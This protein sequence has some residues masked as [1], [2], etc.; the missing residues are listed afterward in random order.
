MIRV[1]CGNSVFKDILTAI[2]SYAA[3]Q[4]IIGVDP[5]ENPFVDDVDGIPIISL[6]DKKLIASSLHKV[7]IVDMITE[8]FNVLEHLR[9]Y[10]K[11]KTYILFANGSWHQSQ[12]D[13]EINH[14][15][16]NWNYFLYD[17]VNRSLNPRVVD[18]WQDKNY[19]FNKNKEFVFSALI[20]GKRSWRDFLV[21][22]IHKCLTADN[23]VLNY[24]GQEL[25]QSSRYD[26]IPYDRSQ[27]NSCK[28]IY[29]HYTLSSSIPI[30]LYNKSRLLLIVEATMYEHDEFHLTEKTIKALLT[31]IPFVVCGSYKFLEQLRAL[32][33]KTYS[34]VW[35][36]EYD[37]IQNNQDRMASIVGLL[38][39]ISTMDWDQSTVDKLQNIA[40]HNK[41]QLLNV[42]SIM[43]QQILTIVDQFKDFNI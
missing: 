10:P 4:K 38:N 11:D 1:N 32:G 42:N 20:G 43:K 33:F 14:I 5:I 37:L 9:E 36:E 12:T 15:V 6:T 19:K 28:S 3:Y 25:K 27:F 24:A 23:Y 22:Q 29:Q 21:N 18:S 34:E 26:D 40:Y 39:D 7:I 31:G 8:G 41:L 17:Y 13:L 16:I 2:D 35:S 30:N